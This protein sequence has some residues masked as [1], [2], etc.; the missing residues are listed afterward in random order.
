MAHLYM[1]LFHQN[2]EYV[3]NKHINQIQKYP[4]GTHKSTYKKQKNIKNKNTMRGFCP[5]CKK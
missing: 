2:D 5:P 1:V 4:T 3:N